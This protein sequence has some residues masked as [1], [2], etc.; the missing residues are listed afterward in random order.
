[1]GMSCRLEIPEKNFHVGTTFSAVCTGPYSQLE[2]EKAELKFSPEQKYSLKMTGLEVVASEQIKIHLT[3][4]VA[5]PNRIM[6]VQLFDG[7]QTI[8]LGNFEFN[9]ES[10]LKDP[11]QEPFSPIGPMPAQF[12]ISLWIALGIFSAVFVLLVVK[13]FRQIKRAKRE[14]KILL[15]LQR[16]LPP[17]TEFLVAC[18]E[19]NLSLE[20]NKMSL[21]A[22]KSEIEKS[23]RRALS[24]IS[25][26]LFLDLKRTE[27]FKRLK[28]FKASSA[29]GILNEVMSEFYGKYE[30]T[31]EDLAQLIAKSRRALELLHEELMRSKG[32]N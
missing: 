30:P 22:A 21:G 16:S 23:I 5:G 14:R 1:M 9:V 4:L 2:M 11:K 7:K 20:K 29:S 18:R 13:I 17:L 3:S 8:P 15:D 10:V 25:N 31:S 32:A 19:V 24:R 12:P 6:D 27:T 26:V 28:M